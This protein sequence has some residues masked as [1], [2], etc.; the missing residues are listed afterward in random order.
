MDYIQASKVSLAIS[1]PTR[2]HILELLS[3]QGGLTAK[4]IQG[5]LQ[6]VID[7]V[8]VRHHLNHLAG[9]GLVRVERDGR[10]KVYHIYVDGILRCKQVLDDIW[11]ALS[12]HV[13]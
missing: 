9:I 4:M 8:T 5:Q 13:S 12:R 11:Q 6:E 1:H 2:L 7:E 10:Y 3:A